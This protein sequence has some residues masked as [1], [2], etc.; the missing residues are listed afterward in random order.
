MLQITQRIFTLFKIIRRLLFTIAIFCD[1]IKGMKKVLTTL[2]IILSVI[3][4]AM[5]LG[6]V[7]LAEKSVTADKYIYIGSP[8]SVYCGDKIYV[9]GDDTLYV[10][11][12][13]YD[14][15][16]TVHFTGLSAALGNGNVTVLSTVDGIFKLN[17]DGSTTRI[18]PPSDSF[19]LRGDYLYY[20]EGDKVCMLSVSLGALQQFDV[21]A[22]VQS[23][24]SVGN[25]VYYAVPSSVDGYSDI[26]L[27]NFDGS[28]ELKYDYCRNLSKLLGG[29]KIRYYSA[30]YAVCPESGERVALGGD[31]LDL[32]RSTNAF[33]YLTYGGELY[34][35]EEGKSELVFACTGSDNG[36]FSFPVA[37]YTDFGRLFVL[38]Y[39][40]DRVAVY[41][42]T[43][44]YIKAQRPVAITSDYSGNLYISHKNGISVY[45]SALNK[46]KD[47][48]CPYGI[49]D[50]LAFSDGKIF[51][52]AG[53]K[54]YSYDGTFS[55]ALGSA[56]KIKSEYF[57]G[58]IYS[59]T[60]KGVVA[61]DS[62]ATVVS[63]SNAV[64]FDVDYLGAVYILKDGKITKFIS[65]A[66]DGTIDAPKSASA[67][68]LST[69]TNAYVDYGNIVVTE[70]TAHSVV[71]VKNDWAAAIPN[72]NL[73]LT[74]T[75]Q[76]IRTA[77][78]DCYLYE[79][80]CSNATVCKIEKDQTV[81]VGKYTLFE[82]ARMSYALVETDDGLKSGYMYKGLLSQPEPD[83]QPSSAGGTTVFDN[84]ALFRFPSGS[85]EKLIDSIGK[86]AYVTLLP[87]AAYECD[88]IEWYRVRYDAAGKTYFGFIA[89]DMLSFSEYTPSNERPQ[90]NAKLKVTTA[91]YNP[92]G[93]TYV[94]NGK[95][96]PKGTEV[97]VVGVYDANR[98]FTRIKYYD[99][100]T[101]VKEAY[102]R[103]VALE[104][105]TV[106]PL[107]IIGLI[108]VGV[109]VI[110]IIIVFAI[111][112]T[113][114]RKMI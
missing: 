46:T 106:T 28:T 48:A 107:Q 92:L 57:G 108:S 58:K 39:A 27:L 30:G 73:Q 66:A 100:L 109:V 91:L 67:I 69:V 103:T 1:K 18:A 53:G 9:V 62:G 26:Y 50:S 45:D 90:Y 7:A 35:N 89:K 12:Y 52:T 71:N 82:T 10:F 65:G 99:N 33:Y 55:Q 29:D 11:S 77:L 72:P 102:V 80:P 81:I 84:T 111:K 96:L 13:D 47:I 17:S 68:S 25:D 43:L 31:L 97:E 20:A 51:L 19:T 41:D 24:C 101:G 16:Q 113:S 22:P 59:L 74:D 95:T 42:D 37:S 88:G 86:G 110:L 40:N 15:E 94:E 5:P 2:I 49:A 64:D 83:V 56:K 38:D 14:L 98:E 105:Y 85:S 23:V 36:Y 70:T 78:G 63:E 112:Y 8:E 61:L 32:S 4:T 54:I 76:I 114:R 87:F 3:L 104:Y 75:T 6:T 44:S 21:A 79:S 34:V 93:E 60:D